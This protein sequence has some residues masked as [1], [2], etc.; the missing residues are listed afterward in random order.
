MFSDL[1]VFQTT[2]NREGHPSPKG[3]LRWTAGQMMHLVCVSIP[4]M[5]QMMSP[6]QCKHSVWKSWVA[7]VDYFLRLLQ[8]EFSERDL[9]R[10]ETK[11]KKAHKAF[12]N[13]P[14]FDK[15]WL[16]KHHFAL[17]F[18]DDI[19]R[20]GPPRFYW[21]MRFES[22]NQECKRAA[23]TGNYHDTA[24][25]VTDFMVVRTAERLRRQKVCSKLS[26]ASL[27]PNCLVRAVEDLTPEACH[28]YMAAYT[29]M[30]KP[31]NITRFKAHWVSS[32]ACK[33]VCLT[34]G[35]WILVR[36]SGEPIYIAQV[37]TLFFV[38][39]EGCKDIEHYFVAT[40]A[41]LLTQVATS[42][43]GMSQ[44]IGNMIVEDAA[45]ESNVCPRVFVCHQLEVSELVQCRTGNGVRTFITSP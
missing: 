15:L 17:H 18:V 31:R 35:T 16:P 7:H 24:A 22:K 25:T 45:W 39:D 12:L 9:Q 42:A 19:R 13:V 44:T 33:G 5:S 4:L 1:F 30:G 32:M 20:Y 3:T 23:A 28:E 21:C 8:T 38:Q 14:E 10:L 36:N 2:G 34:N 37:S 27:P 43:C 6:S 26:E 29:I 41:C 40:S 11:I